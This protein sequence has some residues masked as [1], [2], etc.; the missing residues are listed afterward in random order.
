MIVVTL[1]DCPP[2]LRGDLSKWLVEIN[3]GVYVG[4]LNK[5]V[6]EQL[7]S[8]ICENLPK[9]RATMVYSSNN[10]QRME[11]CVHNTT[12]QPVDYDGLTLVRRPLPDKPDETLKS[13]M[14]KAAVALMNQQKSY[15]RTRDVQKGGYVVIDVETTGMD[16]YKDGIIEIGAIRIVKG[17]IVESFSELVK[18]KGEISKEVSALTGISQEMISEKGRELEQVIV[19]FWDF[20][21]KSPLLGHNLR[22][23]L[24]FIG[25]AS[26]EADIVVPSS[27]RMDTLSLARRKIR[28]IP[29]Y[30]LETLADHFGIQV[31]TKHRALA[32]CVTTFHVFEKLNEI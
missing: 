24:S 32:D 29:D 20:A 16:C 3:T 11:F 2:K 27:P 4:Q 31:D 22:F 19:E 10:E 15:V 26:A 21:G 8:R 17:E 1:T 30:R 6:R 13:T 28:D 14:S 12:W 7:W 5:R 23:D 18:Q 25:R 9:G